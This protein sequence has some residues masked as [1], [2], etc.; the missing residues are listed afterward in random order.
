MSAV[1]IVDDSPADRALF[2]TI[3]TRGGLHRPRDG[4]GREAVA[5]AREVRPSA[6]VLD[7][8]LPDV[9][10]HAVCRE[11]KAEHDT[12]SVPVLM[13]TVRDNDADVLSGLE[14]GADDYVAKD[15]DPEIV[16]A[17]VRRLIEHRRLATVAVLNEHLIQVGRLLAGIVHEIRGPLAVIRG[18][19]EMMRLQIKPDDPFTPVGRPDPPQ[20]AALA[21]PPRT[22]D[23]DGAERAERDGRL[24]GRA[25]RQGVGQ[26]VPEGDRPARQPDQDRRRVRRRPPPRPGRRRPADPGAAL[27]L[28]QRA[29][30]VRPVSAPRGGRVTVRAGDRPRRRPRLD[31]DRHRRRRAGHPR[32]LSSN[33]SSSRSSRPR[34]R[35]PGTACT[36]PPR[37]SGSKGAASPSATC[38]AAA[39]ASPSG[40][41]GRTGRGRRGRGRSPKISNRVSFH[42]PRRVRGAGRRRRPV[43]TADPTMTCRAPTAHARPRP[44]T[45]STTATNGR[46][47]ARPGLRGRLDRVGRRVHL[48]PRSGVRRVL[49]RGRGRG[50]RGELLALLSGRAS[51]MGRTDPEA[52]RTG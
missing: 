52:G 17:R 36:W 48:A 31:Q 38:P 11:L 8:N 24:R 49:R 20:L 46:R 6:V 10:G 33:G 19:A 2:R 50:V 12:R 16:L 51:K 13:L 14:A 25:A 27:A 30:G 26:P 32:G 45:H 3:L 35:G 23:G 4:P 42:D 34:R 21:G 43:R 7:V 37:S 47:A 22:P 41:P 28:R 39:P 15:S 9:D 1:L 5:R 29:R 40:S 18:S 44:P